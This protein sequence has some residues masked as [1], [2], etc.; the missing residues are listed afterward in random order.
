MPQ[1][2]RRNADSVLINALACGATNE[3]AAQKAGVSPATVYR[4]KQE[5]EFQRLLREARA[6]MVERTAGAITAMSMEALRA[7]A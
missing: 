1:R 6:G 2:G 4:R 5:P 7:L 3:A